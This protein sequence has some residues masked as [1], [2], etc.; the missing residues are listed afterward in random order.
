MPKSQAANWANQTIWTGDNL[1]VMRGMNSESVDLIYMDPPFNSNQ[2]FAAPIGLAAGAA[3]K[4]V[5]TLDDVDLAWHGEI[6]EQEPALYSIID[7]AGVA[8]GKPMKAYLIMMAVRLMEMRRLLKPTGS[9]YLH[10]DDTASHYLKLL[11]DAILGAQNY[12]N[13]IVWRR[14]TA[15]SD[16]RRFGRILDHILFYAGGDDPFW[17]SDGVLVA[18]TDEQLKAAY[19]STD[20]HGR[21]RSENLTGASASDGESGKPW[22]GYDVSAKNRHW[23]APKTGA[24]AEWIEREFIPGY[25]D[26]DGVHARLDALD[27]AGL[28]HHP[29]RGYWPGLKRYAAA[30]RGNPPQNLILDPIGFTNYN[31]GRGEYVGYPT[32]KPI[33]LLEQIITASSSPGDV[34]LDPFCGCATACVAAENLGRQWVGIDVSPKAAQLVRMRLKNELGLFYKGAHRTDI[35]KRTDLGDVP[36]Y[37]IDANKRYLFGKQ[38]GLCNGCKTLFPYRNLTIDHIVPKSK[39][40]TDHIEN[41]QLLCGACNSTKGTGT[42]EELI[43]RLIREGIRPQ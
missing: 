34:V 15:H 2:N 1:D 11:M 27:D 19:P 29:K 3:F 9:I 7:A 32:Q 12:R 26:I 16:A 35:P 22:Q 17:N 4:D 30:D 41:L 43:A 37:N 21:Y 40:G 42:Q 31:K 10:C 18:K 23:A 33:K 5:W 36:K 14:A 25:R 28:I 20:Q 39:G 13:N 6:A 8:H 38:E 24:Y